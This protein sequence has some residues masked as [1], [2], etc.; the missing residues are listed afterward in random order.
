LLDVTGKVVLMQNEQSIANINNS[1][2]L[3]VNQLPAGFYT[4]Q[5]TQQGN[6]ASAKL[7]VK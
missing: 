2:Q 1:Y 6:I 5:I 4:L 3:N 7:V